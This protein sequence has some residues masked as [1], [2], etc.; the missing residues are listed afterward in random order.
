MRHCL[1]DVLLRNPLLTLYSGAK[2]YGWQGNQEQKDAKKKKY[3]NNEK[4][5]RLHLF[6]IILDFQSPK[7]DW[8]QLHEGKDLNAVDGDW[9]T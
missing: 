2:K 6:P 1:R 3:I 5:L 8:N 7:Q 4:K 9:H